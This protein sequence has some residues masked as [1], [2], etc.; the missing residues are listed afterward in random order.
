MNTE[1]V[2]TISD[3]QPKKVT[4]T[5]IAT[6][7]KHVSHS[8]MTTWLECPYR[9]KLKYLDRI[10]L[11]APSEHTTFGHVMHDALKT[12]LET[13]KLLKAE[14]VVKTFDAAL[15][16]HNLQ[17]RVTAP[18]WQNQIEPILSSVPDFL[19]TTF[20]GWEYI[21]AEQLLYEDIEDEEEYK[22]KGYIDGI[23]KVPRHPRKGS[24][25][26]LPEKLAELGFDYW[27]IDWKCTSWGWDMEKKTNFQKTSQLALYKYFWA[28]KLGLA[29]KDVRCGFILLK[30]T[31]GKGRDRCEL[32]KVS[33][34]EKAVEKALETIGAMIGS[35]R[36]GFVTKKRSN[37]RYCVYNHTEHCK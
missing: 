5:R 32:V 17:D 31:P 14:G 28:K 16:E 12:Y 34:G 25:P 13:N 30:R 33:V 8:E 19:Q 11:D 15:L 36:K 9:H 29:L 24:K 22:F 18:D 3:P 20:P 4:D 10:D 7:G 35:I 2:T 27:I 23:I 26:L 6:I 37:C 1:N 21:A